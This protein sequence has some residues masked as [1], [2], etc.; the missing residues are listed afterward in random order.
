M[1]H[2]PFIAAAYAVTIGAAVALALNAAARLRAARRALG[3][4]DRG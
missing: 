2:L 4:L 3:E 1:T